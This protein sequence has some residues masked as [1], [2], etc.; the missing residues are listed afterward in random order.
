MTSACKN[1]LNVAKTMV[2]KEGEVFFYYYTGDN[3]TNGFKTFDCKKWEEEILIFWNVLSEV[4]IYDLS[5]PG[6]Q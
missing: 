6:Y 4:K 1:P 2:R 5:L 3:L